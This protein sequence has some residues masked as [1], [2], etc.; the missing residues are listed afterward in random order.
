MS[1]LGSTRESKMAEYVCCLTMHK[2]MPQGSNLDHLTA[3]DVSHG[4]IALE[5]QYMKAVLLV[6]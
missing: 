3:E 2:L 5:Q 1:G 6:T 4:N